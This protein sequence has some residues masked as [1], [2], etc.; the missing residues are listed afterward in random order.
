MCSIAEFNANSALALRDLR[1]VSNRC[2]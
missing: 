1:V 2:D